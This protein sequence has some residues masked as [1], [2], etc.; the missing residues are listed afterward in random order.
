M[1]VRGSDPENSDSGGRVTC[2]LYGFLLF[3]CRNW[4]NNTKI[5][6][7]KGGVEA[8]PRPS[9]ISAHGPDGVLQSCHPDGY[10]TASSISCRLKQALKHFILVRSFAPWCQYE[11]SYLLKRFSYRKKVYFLFWEKG[12][13]RVFLYKTARRNNF[14][15]LFN[16]SE[17]T[18]SWKTC[19]TELNIKP[20]KIYISELSRGR[21]LSL[22]RTVI[23]I[24]HQE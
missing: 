5:N 8:S 14:N 9:S 6:R 11:S 13:S 22:G 23:F 12:N 20:V 10:S 1:R 2:Q 4:N 16:A 3:C 21:L 15:P 18:M 7:K 19:I 24:S 17:F